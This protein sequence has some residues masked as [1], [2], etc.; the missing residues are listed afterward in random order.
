ME[1]L[2]FNHEGTAGPKPERIIFK[3]YFENADI[4]V[5][6]EDVGH[7]KHAEA[8]LSFLDQYGDKMQGLF[9]ELSSELQSSVDAY[10]REGTIDKGLNDLFEGASAEGKD[11]KEEMLSIFDKGKE[12][13]IKIICFDAAKTSTPEHY[14]RNADGYWF[15]KGECRDEDMFDCVDDYY[16]ENA[17][18]YL[19]VIGSNHTNNKK[20]ADGFDNFGA[21]LKAKFTGRCVIVRMTNSER[22]KDGDNSY[23][24]VVIDEK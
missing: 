23:D 3:D 21:R 5:L 4:V 20:R 24:D 11:L 15:I 12:L 19:V 7:G 18:K 14:R 9:I 17:G 22:A 10:I 6:A 1:E 16:K 2:R 8:I 13:N